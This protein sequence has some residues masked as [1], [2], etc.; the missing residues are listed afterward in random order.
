MCACGS[1]RLMWSV[2]LDWPPPSSFNEGFAVEPKITHS[3]ILASVFAEGTPSLH[4]EFWDTSQEPQSPRI[5]MIS[6]D[7][8]SGLYTCAC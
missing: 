3:A 6:R 2:F 1:L 8:N 5:Y 4:F 7:L